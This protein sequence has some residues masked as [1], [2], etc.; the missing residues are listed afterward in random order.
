[1][2]P[3]YQS[4]TVWVN[5]ITIT[6]AVLATFG[7]TPDQRLTDEIARVLLALSPLINLVLRFFTTKPVQ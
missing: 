1:M 7:I 5:A 2:K 6:V 3:W 4:K